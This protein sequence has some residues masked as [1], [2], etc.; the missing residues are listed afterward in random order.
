MVLSKGYV[1]RLALGWALFGA[2]LFWTSH[3]F[4]G[5]GA[6]LLYFASFAAWSVFPLAHFVAA[7]LAA[8]KLGRDPSPALA[9]GI[10]A[11]TMALIFLLAASGMFNWV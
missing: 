6:V 1:F 4:I 5:G 8:R 10:G 9:I 7:A 2:L 3:K 11:G